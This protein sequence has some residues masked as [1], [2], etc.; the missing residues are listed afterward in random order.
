MGD[1]AE[2]VNFT[3]ECEAIQCD[4]RNQIR[5]FKDATGDVAECYKKVILDKVWKLCQKQGK[6]YHKRLD[7]NVKTMTLVEKLTP[8][9]PDAQW[10]TLLSD[11]SFAQ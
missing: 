10:D 7:K 3:S 9:M 4:I 2:Y 11:I 6:F 8:Q 1:Y 5:D